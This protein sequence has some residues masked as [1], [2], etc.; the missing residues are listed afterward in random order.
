[1]CSPWIIR[2]TA[3]PAAWTSAAA[4]WEA[5]A[6]VALGGIGAFVMLVSPAINGQ[7]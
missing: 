5:A 2:S 4:V 6:F 1:M 7:G 3:A